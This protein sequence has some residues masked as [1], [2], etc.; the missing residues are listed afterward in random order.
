MTLLCVV[1]SCVFVALP[2]GV[3]GQMLYL[4]VSILALCLLG[5]FKMKARTKTYASNIAGCV[6][7]CHEVI[8]LVSCSTQLSMKFIRS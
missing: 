2:S 4:V 5:Y 7:T 6:S 8:T 3:P 1:V